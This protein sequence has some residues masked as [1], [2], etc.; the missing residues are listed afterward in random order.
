MALPVSDST[1]KDTAVAFIR[2]MREDE[3]KRVQLVVSDKATADYEGVISV[4]NGVVLDDGTVIDKV[5]ATAYVAGMT[6]GAAVNES[7]TY[8]VY[9]DATDVD[10]RYLN[11]EIISAL[12]AGEF[13]F[14]ER[15]G[16]AYVEQDINTFV[17]F[18]S[19]KGRQFSKN[20]LLRVM[21]T[22]GNDIKSIFEANYLGKMNNSKDGRNLFKSEIVTYVNSLVNIG[23]VEDFD[24]SSDITVE[25]GQT[26]E[27]VV[28]SL[29][30]K[31]ADSAEKVGLK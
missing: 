30:I 26:S 2:R 7:C 28:V 21:D 11:S 1:I 25:A 13:L 9:D 15:N 5:K 10:T 4:K 22:L 20:R 17:S 12:E 8:D 24:G 3:G 19:S 31:P 14:V 6:A 16:K 27:S 23:A 29:N 18:A